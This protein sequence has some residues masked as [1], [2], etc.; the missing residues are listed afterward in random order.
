MAKANKQ[1]AVSPDE[2]SVSYMSQ[3]VLDE[4]GLDVNYRNTARRKTVP[5][6]DIYVPDGHQ[7]G[8]VSKAPRNATAEIVMLTPKKAAELLRR[9][10]NNRVINVTLVNRL[11]ETISSG[12]WSFNGEA[13]IVS[14]DGD[15]NDGQHRCLAVLKT[16]IAVPTVLVTGVERKTRYT[17]DTGAKRSRHHLLQMRGVPSSAFVSRVGDLLLAFRLKRVPFTRSGVKLN[18]Y[19][20]AVRNG[21]ALDHLD[22]IRWA[23][24]HMPDP[25]ISRPVGVETTF[26]ATLILLARAHSPEAAL[27]FLIPLIRGEMLEPDGARI[28]ARRN[29]QTLKN[30][31]KLTPRMQMSIV[32]NA[33]NNYMAADKYPPNVPVSE[34]WPEIYTEPGRNII[35]PSPELEHTA[36]EIKGYIDMA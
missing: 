26:A 7:F 18:D 12:M 9:N 5:D 35:T 29:L 32:M 8:K 15:L 25:K 11:A 34:E 19:S 36:D 20:D 6:A 2:K 22:E 4:L 10:D 16:G 13:I 1:T 23:G 27:D 31:G 14:K 30:Y 3:T 24:H 21:Y 28:T 33:W 17:V